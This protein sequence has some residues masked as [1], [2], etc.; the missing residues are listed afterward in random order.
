MELS[1]VV[2]LDVCIFYVLR[3]NVASMQMSQG[4]VVNLWWCYVGF[5]EST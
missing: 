1:V 3:I 2:K 4:V 5:V